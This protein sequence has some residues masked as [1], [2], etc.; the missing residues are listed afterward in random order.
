[1]DR[2]YRG[3]PLRPNYR[4]TTMKNPLD[5]LWGTIVSG[6]ILTLI[7]HYAVKYYLGG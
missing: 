1:L 4:E 3:A 5:S 2:E 7:L 6:L